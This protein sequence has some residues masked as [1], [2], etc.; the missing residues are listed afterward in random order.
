MTR[1]LCYGIAAT[2]ALAMLTGA[3]LAKER[4]QG[5]PTRRIEHLVVII[6]E[7]ISFDHYFAT[8]PRAANLPGEPVF[9]ARDGT[10]SVNG[11]DAGLLT[12]NPNSF[13]PFRLNRAQQRR[14]GPSPAYTAEQRA[15]NR[16]LMDKFPQF[17]GQISNTD[18]PCDFGLGTNVVM[19]YYDGNTVTALW[20]Y[21][22]HFA[23]SDNF[24]GTTF[25]Q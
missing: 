3:D 24:F 11:L 16:G 14:C 19:G 4:T 25:G 17:T 20:N 6:Q 1:Y 23:M 5:E 15:F 21:A 13:Q 10:P 2:T 22:Q 12:N 7:N 8:Y 18:P 9:I